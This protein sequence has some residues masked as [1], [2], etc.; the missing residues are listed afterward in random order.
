[1][2]FRLDYYGPMTRPTRFTLASLLLALALCTPALRAQGAAAP[3][4][5]NM[6]GALLYELL[7]AEI[8]ANQGDVQAA[9][10]LT[11]DAA[12]KNRSD[13][14]FERAVEIALRA[15]AGDS[16]LAAAQEWAQALPKSRDA[17]RYQLQILIGLNKLGETVEPMRHWLQSS[18]GSER[19]ADIG[20]LPR[21][22]LRAADKKLAVKVVE[23]ALAPDTG[24]AVTGPAAFAA[25]GTMRLLAEDFD[26]ALEAASKGA[27]L[28]HKA[29]EPALL[30]LA[31]VDAK[32]PAAEILVLHM[33][34]AGAPPE[35]QMAYVRKLLEAQRY[36]EAMD[37]VQALNRQIPTLAEAWLVRG[38]LALQDKNLA[39]AKLALQ[40]Y[41]QLRQAEPQASTRTADRGLSQAY[42]MLADVAEQEQ[43]SDEAERYLAL[44]DN[45]QEALRVQS[46][47]AAILARSGQMDAA[48]ALIRAVPEIQDED[49]RAK[50]SAEVQLLR[51][52]KQY[53]QVY[54]LLRDSVARNPDDIDLRYDLAMA[55]EKLDKIDEMEQLLRQVIADKPDYLH[56]YNALG[57]SLADRH[58][59]LP[60]ARQLI[61][62]ALEFAPNDPFIQDSLGWV[63]FRSGN[64]AQAL[65]ILQTAFKGRPDAEIAAHLGEV[66]WDLKQPEQARAIW[67]QGL[68]Q[69]PENDTLLETI[70]RLSP[71]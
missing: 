43:R 40:T 9:F 54:E 52:N 4:N 10:Q 63:E 38:S 25:I 42:L 31:L 7:L 17:A 15:R 65:Q 5:S 22:F 30:A 20:Q 19:A 51:D 61:Q 34:D 46:R 37:R 12:R 56:A 71:P 3:A 2:A 28:N 16:A 35:V 32:H 11:L 48:R 18:S 68:A 62:K 39:Q 49:G 57:Y 60:E 70:K 8:S 45:P 6:T 33:L 69:N 24:N 41:V 44:V 29:A 14:L 13:Q 64:L 36:P 59:R 21:F 66:L 67:Q 50:L 58:L 1:M 26:G 27:N 23:Q 53:Q 47:R 55:A